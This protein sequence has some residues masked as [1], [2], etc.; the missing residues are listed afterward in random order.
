MNVVLDTTGNMLKLT[1][2]PQN[3]EIHLWVGPEGGWSENERSK[4]K[5]NGFIFVRF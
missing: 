2:M 3:D 5:E 1:E 4:M